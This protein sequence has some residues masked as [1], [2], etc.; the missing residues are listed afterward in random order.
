ML[1]AQVSSAFVPGTP[2]ILKP[3]SQPRH[4]AR[5]AIG[6]EAKLTCV[7]PTLQTAVVVADSIQVVQ[8]VQLVAGR[9][10]GRLLPGRPGAWP[11]PRLGTCVSLGHMGSHVEAA[12]WELHQ[13]EELVSSVAHLTEPFEVDD[14]YI[15]QGPQ[16]Q[17]HRALLEDFAVGALPRIV[18]GQL[19]RKPSGL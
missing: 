19:E 14:E 18:L 8:E 10:A 3:R 9:Q 6:R 4:T 7:M 15:G 5:A 12:E 13:R 11:W 2:G 17:L 16:T 1:N